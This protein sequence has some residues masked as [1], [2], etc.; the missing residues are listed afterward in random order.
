MEKMLIFGILII[1]TSD[2][3]RKREP[4]SYKDHQSPFYI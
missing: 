3:F 4:H 1:N 2:S